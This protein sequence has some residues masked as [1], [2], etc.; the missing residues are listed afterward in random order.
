MND[1]NF[2]DC[3]GTLEELESSFFHILFS[4]TTA[5]ISPLLL[6]YYDFCVFFFFSF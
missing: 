1:I 3:D 5:F 4:W 6:S 2:E